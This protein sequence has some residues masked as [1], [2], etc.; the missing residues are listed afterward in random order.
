MNLDNYIQENYDEVLSWASSIYGKSEIDSR[1]VVAELYIDLSKRP[2]KIKAI[3]N[4]KQMKFYVL[5]WLKSRT[6]WQGG[7]AVNRYKIPENTLNDSLP[8]DMF[9]YSMD[10]DEVSEDLIRAGF[11][12][13]E[14]EKITSCIEVSKSMPLYYKRLFVLYY[15]DGMTM[16]EIGNSCNLPKSAIFTQLKKVQAHL[17]TSL[18]LNKEEV[19]L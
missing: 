1:D 2:E 3:P 9:I 12:E 14:I 4:E 10:K 8:S 16:L 11:N 13:W 19:L 5:R 18:K 6:Y 17:K 15:I 7:N